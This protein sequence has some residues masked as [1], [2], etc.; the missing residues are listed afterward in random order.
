MFLAL[1]ADNQV[2]NRD[3]VHFIYYIK[4]INVISNIF[5]ADQIKNISRCNLDKV[6]LKTVS[7]ANMLAVDKTNCNREKKRKKTKVRSFVSHK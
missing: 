5:K 7:V 1:S 4:Y 2:C 3:T 6:K